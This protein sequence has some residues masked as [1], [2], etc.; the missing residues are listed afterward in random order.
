MKFQVTL[1]YHPS[2]RYL[3]GITRKLN[4]KVDL[5]DYNMVIIRNLV[6]QH[7]KA[8]SLEIE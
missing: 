8:L 7:V 4:F 5:N 6:G 2:L 3:G 1:H